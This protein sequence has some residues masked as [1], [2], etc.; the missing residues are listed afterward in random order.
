MTDTP[1]HPPLITL[2]DFG[3]ASKKVGRAVDENLYLEATARWQDSRQRLLDLTTHA[4][5][6]R[7]C[8]KQWLQQTLEMDGDSVQVHFFAT[9][10]TPDRYI[11]LTQAY[12]FVQ[13]F[14]PL[15]VS[16]NQ[17]CRIIGLKDPY[18]ATRPVELLHR[19]KRMQ[20]RELLSDRWATYWLDRAPGTAMSRRSLAIELYS[21][22]LQAAGQVAC[23]LGT[24]DA[25]HLKPL[26]ALIDPPAGALEVDGNK[27]YVEQLLL[28]HPDK[29]DAPLPGALVLTLDT[30]PS[31]QLLY[32]P[33][34]QPALML[35]SQR[36]AMEQWLGE[37]SGLFHGVT[38]RL[39]GQSIV[40]RLISDALQT[41]LSEL[42][43]QRFKE[44][45]GS[46]FSN[47][48][49]D[50][51]TH[52]AKALDA[53]E[54]VEQLHAGQHFFAEPP[55]PLIDDGTD[56]APP[57]AFN[58]LTADLPLGLRRSA[59]KQQ[60]L[61][62]D[63]LLGQNFE[64]NPDDP[65]LLK[66]TTSFDALHVAQQEANQAA[67]AL[68]NRTPV[69]KL[70]ELQNKTHADYIAL[71]QARLRG[72]MHEAD[73][74]LQLGQINASEHNLLMVLLDASKATQ[75]DAQIVVNTLTLIAS[76]RSNG[77]SVTTRKE[78]YGVLLIAQATP[79]QDG[80][81]LYWPGKAGGLLRLD[82]IAALEQWLQVDPNGAPQT[83]LERKAL[84]Q[85]AFDYSLQMQL[86]GYVQHIEALLRRTANPDDAQQQAT[87][88][89]KIR[90]QAVHELDV[91]H[92][93][94]RELAYAQ[95]QEQNQSSALA[96]Q[97]P[98]W[99]GHLTPTE[100]AQLKTSIEAYLKA[101]AQADALHDLHLPL[102]S[103]FCKQGLDARLAQDFSLKH[104]F[105]V[106]LDLPASVSHQQ[107]FLPAPGAPSTPTK[108]VPVPSKERV[109]MSLGELALSNIDSAISERLAFMK[110]DI[111]SESASERATLSTAV[112]ASYLKKRVPELNLAQHYTDLIHKTYLG[113]TSEAV[114]S[115]EHRLDCLR[116]PYRLM[117]KIQG[118]LA[119]LQKNLTLDELQC[120]NIAIEAQTREAW[121]VQ[122]DTLQL[123]PAFLST[124]GKDTGDGPSTLSGITFI[125]LQ[126]AGRTL[127]YLPDSPD[128]RYLRRFDSLEAARMALF[129]LCLDD[130]MVNY[131]AQ[132]A[133]LGNVESHISRINQAMLKN[134]T[135]LIGVGAPWPV[136][137]SLATH[138]LHAQM[139]R[140]VEA[141][142]ATSRSNSDLYLERYALKG[143]KLFN[144]LKMAVG[145]VP[146]VGTVIGLYD[147][148]TSANQAVEAFRRGD[149][150]QGMQDIVQVLQSLIDAGIDLAGGVFITPN[151]A[152][153]R[154]VSRQLRN[155]FKGGG[156]VQLPASRK[157]RHIAER[158]KS[159][160]Y[161]KS[162]SLGHLQPATHGLYR[163]IYRH[164]DGNFIVRQDKVYQVVLQDGQ[165][166]L[167]GNSQKLYKQPIALDEAGQWDT[168]FGVY[169][170]L[171][172]GGL[173]GGGSVLGHLA[174]RLEPLWPAGIR[175]RLPIWWTDGALRRRQAIT[176]KIDTLGTQL[177]SQLNA[178]TML[179]RYSN[180]SDP[181]IR[182]TLQSGLEQSY[183][184][185]INLALQHFHAV[186][187]LLPMLPARDHLVLKG[188]QSRDAW[189]ITERY[190]AQ[191]GIRVRRLHVLATK[192]QSINPPSA[193]FHEAFFGYLQTRKEQSLKILEA[194][195]QVDTA[196]KQMNE[197]NDRINLRAREAEI[198]NTGRD[199]NQSRE[200]INQNVRKIVE[201]INELREKM[202]QWN[203]LYSPDFRQHFRLTHS[204]ETFNRYDQIHDPSWLY[205]QEQLI[206]TH[207]RIY[208]AAQ[209]HFSLT[210]AR[211][212]VNAS[213]SQRKK[214]L[215]DCIQAYDDFSLSLRTLSAGYPQHFDL[216]RIAP[217]LIDIENLSNLA[218]KH[219]G[220]S[221]RPGRVKAGAPSRKVFET[222]D[223]QLLIGVEKVDEATG[224]TRYEIENVTGWTETWERK[225]DGKIR[226]K[227]PPA[228]V[229][230][231]AP[232]AK[233]VLIA[234]ARAR[235]DGVGAYQGRVEGYA[236][237]NMLPVDLEQMMVREASELTLRANRIE[238]VAPQEAI[239]A[240]LNGKAG[241]LTRTG[242]AL[243]IRE[244]LAS[245]RPTDGMLD[246]LATQHVVRID[247][248]SELKNLGKRAD[249]RTDYMQEYEIWDITATPQHLVWYAHFHYSQASPTF[250]SFEK[251]HLK[252]PQHRFITHADDPNLPYADIGK[253]SPAL[254]H[255]PMA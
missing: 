58:D 173:A 175:E 104:P 116:E 200:Q 113:A 17:Q 70:V 225:G 132:R 195:D 224:S 98:E 9:A 51:A 130:T 82:N 150:V 245:Q 129:N 156:Y 167:S 125:H 115:R 202:T 199:A 232:P 241:E 52:G 8:I 21:A 206:P 222:A 123:L 111:T 29:P 53:V 227:E 210:T 203:E 56:A 11:S 176:H 218:R 253:R 252:L 31:P 72:L 205:L 216:P 112:T 79:A 211:V 110:A 55:P 179:Q 88:L 26:L 233:N 185:D 107:H 96:R 212:R 204:I 75:P 229:P 69:I 5:S 182:E 122:G 92:H 32:L 148:W 141:H 220:E 3:T 138:L 243:R 213:V 134:F 120:W 226:R 101:L 172:N 197:W 208:R 108:T 42:L 155:A 78:L 89:E 94:A 198:R 209:N 136:T 170:T 190:E 35:F 186:D 221:E 255:F 235:L 84:S 7:A 50:L 184:Q 207:E 230:P 83:S 22:H 223:E 93:P 14:P 133:L 18:Y 106:Q 144:Y 25:V 250:A 159:Y 135:A 44:K 20:A 41:G 246:Y 109:T 126:S 114:F 166:R 76:E 240:E 85:N 54:R 15:D 27:M 45:L 214:I 121:Q 188:M 219:I 4:P 49:S 163:G 247:K 77:Q 33:A 201:H 151:A 64:G 157:A 171:Q 86:Y 65:R 91:C 254:A 217:L 97:L 62:L 118:Q 6:A 128:G 24:I 1:E 236:R 251:A 103:T 28:K 139:G 67:S 145:V 146:I 142:R 183:T 39:A 12:A 63:T 181:L 137:T 193:A 23:A 68:F 248:K 147:A 154:T 152:R 66:L 71:Y 105:T 237:Q 38:Q 169:G 161:E 238:R 192:Q 165:W 153:T 36:A 124:G 180:Q 196:L 60:K 174:D 61:A 215:N 228:T 160:E 127:L 59:V 95:L 37:Q 13:Q 191:L 178:T 231:A 140:L 30:E 249:G 2:V 194:L 158:F 162:L 99:L 242:R 119:F 43:E 149:H 10:D 57:M 117:L 131:L 100:K 102:S 189:I 164:A 177:D 19:L 46:L 239:I 81:L 87:E 73:I 90:L 34:R 74:Q 40:Y 244:S 80:V 143:E 187:E 168:H 16:L 234:E 47:P 48:N